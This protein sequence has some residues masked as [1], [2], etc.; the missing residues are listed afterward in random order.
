[1]LRQTMITMAAARPHKAEG[2][3]HDLILFHMVS[4]I[5]NLLAWWLRNLDT[6]DAQTMGEIIERTVLTPLSQLRLS[7]PAALLSPDA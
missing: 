1:M 5:L 6:V 3:L 2:P 7:P 4:A